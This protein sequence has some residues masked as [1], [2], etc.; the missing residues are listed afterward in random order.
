[1]NQF[2]NKVKTF[3]FL[4]LITLTHFGLATNIPICT[5]KGNNILTIA[6]AGTFP[7]VV[8]N[9][10]E[11]NRPAGTDIDYLESFAKEN[12]LKIEWVFV[13][14][15][16]L[17][18][19]AGNGQS[20]IAANGISY[21]AERETNG[22]KFSKP[23]FTVQ[24]SLLVKSTHNINIIDN[25]RN[26]IIGYVKGSIPLQDMINRGLITALNLEMRE[27]ESFEAGKV[28]LQNDEISAFADGHVTSEFIASQDKS[29][30]VID[31]HD[32]DPNNPENFVFAVRNQP[33]VESTPNECTNNLLN[34]LNEFIDKNP[35]K[36]VVSTYV[37]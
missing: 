17:W 6:I 29:F 4:T 10:N 12:N 13:K 30:K 7:P 28:A 31:T 35:Y 33:L 37:N 26:K 36:N 20:D 18:G 9:K 14:F 5:L 24:R 23:Y 19:T 11:D 32:Y 16:E 27:F 8:I 1:M 25:L 22:M 2:N 34:K 21:L 15:D 3:I